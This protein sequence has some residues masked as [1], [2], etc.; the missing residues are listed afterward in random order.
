MLALICALEGS[1]TLFGDARL[2]LCLGRE[3]D[4]LVVWVVAARPVLPIALVSAVVNTQR[5]GLRGGRGALVGCA[6]THCCC[7]RPLKRNWKK[8]EEGVCLLAGLLKGGE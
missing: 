4:T 7:C 6:L 3:L 8:S 2:D 1:S 5:L